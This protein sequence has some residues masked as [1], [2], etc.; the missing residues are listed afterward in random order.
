MFRVVIGSMDCRLYSGQQCFLIC[1]CDDVPPS[2]HPSQYKSRNNYLVQI[3]GFR[4]YYQQW[5]RDMPA[6][7]SED[8]QVQLQSE[9]DSPVTKTDAADGLTD[10][11]RNQRAAARRF[12]S[13]RNNKKRALPLSQHP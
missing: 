2:F 13:Q 4:G 3:D 7:T 5:L 11:Q 8:E 9:M 6:Q 10:S 1:V 12:N